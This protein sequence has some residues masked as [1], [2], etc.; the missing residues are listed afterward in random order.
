MDLV[1]RNYNPFGRINKA[2]RVIKRSGPRKITTFQ[3]KSKTHL[4]L[5]ERKS[6][7]TIIL[8]I[9]LRQETNSAA[10][11]NE[12]NRRETKKIEVAKMITPRKTMTVKNTTVK[13]SKEK[14]KSWKTKE[15]NG[16]DKSKKIR[17][18]K[19]KK[20]MRKSHTTARIVKISRM[21]KSIMTVTMILVILS[22]PKPIT[23]KSG[24]SLKTSGLELSSENEKWQNI[25]IQTLMTS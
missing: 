7:K 9:K 8:V 11:K 17:L 22:I 5:S 15:K 16:K 12:N 20:D 18:I 6:L 2:I 19:I 25:L 13:N 3:T 4:K 23:K 14:G 24:S 21:S 1:P 10:N